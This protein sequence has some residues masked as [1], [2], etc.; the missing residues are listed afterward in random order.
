MSAQNDGDGLKLL[1]F[2]HVFASSLMVC[3]IFPK[4]LGQQ[5]G[6][7]EHELEENCVGHTHKN[8]LLSDHFRVTFKKSFDSKYDLFSVPSMKQIGHVFVTS[9]H[10]LCISHLELKLLT[11]PPHSSEAAASDYH[12]QQ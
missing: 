12:C 10:E 7:K 2:I 5:A 11:T 4:Y 6:E 1:N 8:V 9:V 3:K